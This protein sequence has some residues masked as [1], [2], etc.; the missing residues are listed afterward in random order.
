M[1]EQTREIIKHPSAPFQPDRRRIAITGANTLIGKSLIESLSEDP[2]YKYIAIVDLEDPNIHSPKTDFHRIDLTE[3]QSDVELAKLFKVKR[4]D[5]LVHLAYLSNPHKNLAWAHEFET[6]GTMHVLNAAA[7]CHLHK[8]ITRSFTSLYGPDA[9]NPSYIKEDSEFKGANLS[10]FFS[11]KFEAYRLTKRFREENPHITV[12][13]L[14]TAP[15]LARDEK[16]LI[17]SYFSLPIIPQQW[18]FD[19]LFQLLGLKD[20]LTMFKQCVDANYPGP[21]NIAADHVLPLSTISALLG[22]FSLPLIETTAKPIARILGFYR[23]Y[24]L[25]MQIW[26]FL[27]YPCIADIRRAK[28]VLGF[29]P[30]PIVDVVNLYINPGHY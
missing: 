11:D 12:T 18:G 26:K 6:I 5:T 23:G 9:K 27:R 13:T 19:P 21:F 24:T 20:A 15:F 7:A 3:S 29:K 10:A 17:S 25:P 2:R 1:S 28:E 14:F 22:K 8:V 16:N 30:Q 4:I